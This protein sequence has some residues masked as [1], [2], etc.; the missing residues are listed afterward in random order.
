MS[1]SVGLSSDFT[2]ENGY[3]LPAYRVGASRSRSSNQFCTTTILGSLG[4]SSAMTKSPVGW[5]RHWHSRSRTPSANSSGGE[6]SIPFCRSLLTPRPRCRAGRTAGHPHS[7]TA[8]TGLLDERPSEAARRRDRSPRKPPRLPGPRRCRPPIAHPGRSSVAIR[9]GASS[10]RS[11]FRRCSR[12]RPGCRSLFLG[13]RCRRATPRRWGTSPRSR[14]SDRESLPARERAA[15]PR[16]Y[17]ACRFPTC[18]PSS[19]CR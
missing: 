19:R 8:G 2:R 15:S 10:R 11:A 4:S 5:T 9:A 18:H 6:S 3:L 17:P 16:R 1:S 14:D 7:T 13:R 12:S